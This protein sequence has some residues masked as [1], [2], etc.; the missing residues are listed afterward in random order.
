HLRQ[1]LALIAAPLLL[2]I[3]DKGMRRLLP[4]SEYDWA[5]PIASGILV[6]SMFVGLPWILRLALGL[7]PLPPG[8]TRDRLE[9]CAVRLRFR[10]SNILL[11]NTHGGIANAMVA[12]IVPWLRYVVLTDRL[13]EELTPQE[14]EAVFGHEIG[15]VKHRHM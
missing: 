15:H 8:P 11:W 1:N 3:I 12:G 10:C 14:V 4:V 9:R 5:F 6:I 2:V 13:V 7:K